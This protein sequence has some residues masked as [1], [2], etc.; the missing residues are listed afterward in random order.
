[1]QY[2]TNNV[3]NNHWITAGIKI[4]CKQKKFLCIMNK[5]TNHSKIKVHCTQ[6]FSVLW[7]LIRKAKGMYYNELSSSAITSKTSWNT[8]NNEIGTATCKK[9][10]QTELNLV[11]K[12]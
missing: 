2:V 5:T 12:I 4:S 3:S 8:I 11:T 6:Y 1:M 9:F 7:K 10:T